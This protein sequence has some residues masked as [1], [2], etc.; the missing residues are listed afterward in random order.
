MI[1][2]LLR[3]LLIASAL[4]VP[5]L[6]FAEKIYNRPDLADAAVRLEAAFAKEAPVQAGQTTQKLLAESGIAASASSDYNKRRAISMLARTVQLNPNDS[7][8]WLLLSQLFRAIDTKNWSERYEFMRRAQASAYKAYLVAST[9][10]LEATALLALAKLYGTNAY[11]ANWRAALDAYAASLKIFEI[12]G[13]RKD[14]EALRAKYGF[15]YTDYTVQSDS[16]TPR[17]CFKFSEQLQGGK[18]DY[19]PFVATTGLANPAIFVEGRELCLEGVQHGQTYNFVLRQGI[20]SQVDETLLKSVDLKIEIPNRTAQVRSVGRNYVL[21]TTGQDGLPLMSVNT[22]QLDVEVYRIGDRNIVPAIRSENFLSQLASYTFKDIGLNQGVK[23]WTGTLDT[24]YDIN[25]DVVTTFPVVE[26]L[27]KMEP[28]IYVLSAVPHKDPKTAAAQSSSEDSDGEDYDEESWKQR[29]TQWFVVSDLGLTAFKSKEGIHVLARS[30]SNA[31]P[32]SKAEVRLLARNNDV[33]ATKTLDELGHAAFDPGLARG[34]GALE[35]GLIVVSTGS[36]YNFIN[37]NQSS[38]DLSDRGVKGRPASGPVDVYVFAERGVYRPA[39]TVHLTALLRDGRG[40]AMDKIPLTAVIRRPDGVEFRRVQ[41]EDKG[42]GGR[43][44]DVAMPA[45]AAHGTW[46]VAFYTDPKAQPVGSTTFLVE[47]YVAE[48]LEMTLT[49]PDSALRPGAESEVTINARYLFGAPGADLK[50]TGTTTLRPASAPPFP[51][52]KDYAIGLDKE[53]FQTVNNGI[54]AEATTNA[55]GKGTLAFQVP[56]TTTPK[57]AELMVL[58][59]L[60][61]DGGR[62]VTRTIT[63]PVLP[64]GPVIGIKQ[65]FTELG[66]NQPATFDA[67]VVNTDGQMQPASRINW[68]LSRIN[69]SYQW[70]YNEG[71]WNYESVERKTKVAEGVASTNGK[72]PASISANVSLGTYKLEMRAPDLGETAQS[73]VT[74]TAGYSGVQSADT[75]DLLEMTID[76]AAYVAGDTMQVKLSPRFDGKATLAV[77]SDT[78]HDLQIVDVSKGGTTVKIPVKSEWGAGAYLVALAHRPLDTAAKRL[79]GRAL[80]LTWFQVDKDKRAL[81]VDI[82][83]PETTLPARE[84]TVPVKVSGLAA[85]EDAYVTLAAVDVGILNLTR[86]ETPNPTQYFFGQKQLS[87]DITDLYG[88]LIDGMQGTKGG[89]RSGGDSL[90]GNFETLPPTEEP[91]ALFSGIVKVGPDGIANIP[92]S[93]PAFNGSGR[94][95]AVAWSKDRVGSA[96]RDLPIRDP[97]VTLVTLPR[98]L[99]IGD[100]TQLYLQID[101]VDGPNGDYVVDFDLNGPVTARAED[102]HRVLKLERGKKARITLPITAT[103]NGLAQIGMAMRGPETNGEALAINRNYKLGIV[104]GTVSTARRIIREIKPGESMTLSTDLLDNIIPDTGAVTLSVSMMSE[105]DVPGLLGGLDR[106]P[107]GCTEQLT[108]RALPLLYLNQLSATESMPADEGVDERIRNTIERILS[109]QTTNGSFGLWSAGSGGSYWLDAYVV[110][111]L[112]RAREMKYEVSDKAFNLA[113]DRLRNYVANTTEI[114]SGDAPAIAYS[115]YVLARNG[116]PVMGDLRYLADTKLNVFTSASAR[117][118]LAAALALLGDRGRAQSTY[119]SAINQMGKLDPK[120]TYYYYDSY[121]TEAAGTLALGP[122]SGATADQTQALAQN[123]AARFMTRDYTSTQEKVWMVMA[124]QALA[125]DAA[126]GISLKLDG[127]SKPA[128]LYRAYRDTTLDRKPVTLTNDGSAN[129]KAVVNVLGN[130]LTPEP[131]ASKGYTVERTYYDMDGK[132][133]DPTRV[134]QNTRLVTVLTV[135]EPAA[136][137]A[138]LLLVDRLPAGFEIDNPKLVDGSSVGNL[139]WL[140][141]GLAPDHTEYRDD[142]FIASFDR[143]VRQPNSISVAYIVRAVSPGTYMH[144][145]A[146][147]EDMYRPERFGRTATGTVEVVTE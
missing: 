35:P 147:A 1:R 38:F 64:K 26:A 61:E 73:S 67:I 15:R 49:A 81:T 8:S 106:Y 108:S 74:F 82:N 42:L 94:L 137:Q 75:P 59:S 54:D 123:V 109:R 69:R 105:I 90:P 30:L 51:I 87:T 52:L 96:S 127:A 3:S 138:Q 93:L 72:A 57:P 45:D 131:A 135:T 102:L 95:M 9:P 89:I 78:I 44:L 146:T 39:E 20:P 37:L 99:A 46:R 34:E 62:S 111:F 16:S 139:S 98:F 48:R 120:A 10:Q 115:V 91:L 112:T 55:Q 145:P 12:P 27:G 83:V 92:L 11:S 4:L 141:T 31:D 68:T 121:L 23:V 19:A 88:Y 77:I 133:V 130:P 142:K 17:V 7:D 128:P 29:A 18:T 2:K 101:N 103:G 65:K 119:A 56:E 113:L 6:A 47:D 70:F 86:Y 104:P 80:G 41:V 110:D 21:P 14:Y 66:E 76:K 36:D 60:D 28:G 114:S 13:I 79:P 118:R 43:T 129:I 63:L 85:G 58:V 125:K 134:K 116:R 53:E 144:P 50:I 32:V 84:I 117:A 71:R 5:T 100:R 136:Q 126:A 33:L 25:K 97:V 107:Y 140:K 40:V 22:S 143:R 124:A 122:E 132:K 24:K